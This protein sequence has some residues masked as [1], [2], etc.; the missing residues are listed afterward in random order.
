M[1]K[2]NLKGDETKMTNAIQ[3]ADAFIKTYASE[4]SYVAI[5]DFDSS[6]KVNSDLYELSSDS[7]RS[8]LS[9]LLPTESDASGGTEISEGVDAAVTVSKKHFV[10]QFIESMQS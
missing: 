6:A 10:K 2:Q 9:S 8:H 3:A 1:F 5:V 7:H 4:G